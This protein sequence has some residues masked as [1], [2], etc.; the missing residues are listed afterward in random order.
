MESITRFTGEHRFLSN[1]YA[2]EVY[3]Y[4]QRYPTVEHA[5]QAAKTFDKDWRDRIRIAAS[6]AAAKALG[7]KCPSARTGRTSRSR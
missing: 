4:Q 2:A 3:L 7:R 6:P 5:F 1:F